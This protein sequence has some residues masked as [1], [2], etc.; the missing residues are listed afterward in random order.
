MQNYFKIYNKKYN[1]YKKFD[2]DITGHTVVSK[3][4]QSFL[5]REQEEKKQG[6]MNHL[7]EFKKKI[8]VEKEMQKLKKEEKAKGEKKFIRQQSRRQSL[9]NVISNQIQSSENSKFGVNTENSEGSRQSSTKKKLSQFLNQSQSNQRMHEE[10]D[11][12]IERENFINSLNSAMTDVKKQNK[13]Q[14]LNSLQMK[15]QDRTTR[16]KLD[17]YIK[18][19]VNV[20]GVTDEK[21]REEELDF[22][23]TPEGIQLNLQV[24]Y[25]DESIESYQSFYQKAIAYEKK[26][27]IFEQSL[28]N[29]IS[30]SEAYIG[31]KQNTIRIIRQETHSILQKLTDIANYID[32]L[33]EEKKELENMTLEKGAS[34]FLS[35]SDLPDNLNLMSKSK[36][37]THSKA[38]I[39]RQLIIDQI[40]MKEKRLKEIDEQILIFKENRGKFRGKVEYNDVI[41]KDLEK[42]IHQKKTEFKNHFKT[43]KVLYKQ[44]L[45]IGKD[46]REKG[47]SWIIRKLKGF[48]EQVTKIDLPKFLDEKAKEYLIIRA[49]QEQDLDELKDLQEFNLDIYK[50]NIKAQQNIQNQDLNLTQVENVLDYTYHQEQ[51]QIQNEQNN[52]LFNLNSTAINPNNSQIAVNITQGSIQNS[53][54]ILGN[55]NNLNLSQ[56]DVSEIKQQEMEKNRSQD[57]KF[58]KRLMQ[59]LDEKTQDI[60]KN[61]VNEYYKSKQTS[62]DLVYEQIERIIKEFDYQNYGQKYNIDC[63]TVLA[64]LFGGEKSDK[65]ILRYGMSKK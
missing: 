56:V 6:L 63:G 17:K 4:K 35:L 43:Q 15:D 12:K 3:A 62:S 18:G 25:S 32:Q 55:Q 61:I 41:I 20:D 33:A 39:Q 38:N 34:G 42:Q 49:K 24:I 23:L 21:Q 44:L 53:S 16:K 19:A 1:R 30:N 37:G 52:E 47:L 40:M 46:V 2:E 36:N 22:D 58:S 48:E 29:L 65:Y 50:N 57:F 28:N 8:K 10:I 60:T 27:G 13:N 45:L 64:A 7:D 9:L 11:Y 54:M 26:S 59:G 31:Q 51:S 14:G 5:K